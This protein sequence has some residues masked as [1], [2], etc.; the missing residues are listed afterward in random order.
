MKHYQRV[1]SIVLLVSFVLAWPVSTARA[2]SQNE[3]IPNPAAEA[4]F[5][6]GLRAVGGVDLE[7]GGFP[8][9]ERVI[10]ADTFL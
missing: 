1:L 5:L 6:S 8:A 2:S 9:E 7:Q 4:Y 10:S 3:L